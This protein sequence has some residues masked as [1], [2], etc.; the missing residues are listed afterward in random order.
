MPF[1][2]IPS[3]LRSHTAQQAQVRVEATTVAAAFESLCVAHPTIRPY[4]FAPDGQLRRSIAVF[5]N[6]EDVRGPSG[7]GRALG[8]H[9]T[10]VVL[11]ALAGG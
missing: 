5:V 1:I 2:E 6:E 11:V 8:T 9:D 10:V 7:F 3:A 4:I